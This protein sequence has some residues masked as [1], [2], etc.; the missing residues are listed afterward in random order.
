MT[1]AF[2]EKTFVPDANTEWWRIAKHESLSESF[3]LKYGSSIDWD[4]VSIYQKMSRSFI[5]NHIPDELGLWHLVNNYS[6]SM[7]LRDELKKLA[8][9]HYLYFDD[10]L[11]FL[12]KIQDRIS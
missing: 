5:L 12:L 9:V 8:R 7:E 3:I 10:Y 1:M 2:N 6:L 11:G 4:Y